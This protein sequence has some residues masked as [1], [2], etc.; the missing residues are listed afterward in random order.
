MRGIA[1]VVGTLFGIVLIMGMLIGASWLSLAVERPMAK[2]SKETERQVYENSI[3]HQQGANSGI[4]QDCANMESNTG[5]MQLTFARLVLSDAGAY[6]GDRG[7]SDTSLACVSKARS[8]L[9]TSTQ[10]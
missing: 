3:A 5:P 1:V 6:S 10:S 2:F 7:L 8:I 4:S 9:A